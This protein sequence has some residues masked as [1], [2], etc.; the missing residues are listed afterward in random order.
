VDSFLLMIS[1]SLVRDLYQRMIDPD[2]SERVMKWGSLLTTLFVG[3][4][5]MLVA[6]NPPRFLQD[7]IVFGSAGQSATFL[8]AMALTLYWPRANAFG[9][10]CAMLS[11]FTAVGGMYLIGRIQTGLFEPWTPFDI[12][13]FL[14]GILGALLGGVIGTLATAPPPEGLTLK[15]FYR[16]RKIPAQE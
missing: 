10:A 3:L 14:W 16:E 1:S 15:Y 13:P 8:V 11:G 4:L 12:H 2:V 6:V 9:T 7:L 5:V